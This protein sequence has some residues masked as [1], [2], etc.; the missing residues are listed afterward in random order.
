MSATYNFKRR[1]PVKLGRPSLYR[2]EYAKRVYAY[3]LLGA[4]DVQMQQFFEVS[5]F[6]WG[7]WKKQ[8]PDFYESLKKGRADADGQ[9]AKSLYQRAT[10]YSHQAVKI[11][12]NDGVPVYVPYVEH[13]PPDSTAMI[14]WLKNRQPHL[15]RDKRDLQMTGE[16][17][18]PIKVQK[19]ESRVIDADYTDI[20]ER[21]AADQRVASG[22]DT[23]ADN[24]PRVPAVIKTREI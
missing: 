3:A 19:I 14:F 18:G 21:F 15:W 8:Y 9:V 22:R 5:N 6:T 23:G 4:T 2:E 7:N 10:G 12:M 11:F 1:T 13:Y 16:D 17:G 20:T 24:P